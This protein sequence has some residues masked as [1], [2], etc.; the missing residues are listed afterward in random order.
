MAQS[1][2]HPREKTLSAAR[3]DTASDA[4]PEPEKLDELLS[5]AGRG[6]RAVKTKVASGLKE[7]HIK[8][9]EQ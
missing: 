5:G 4:E 8:Q 7:V 3:N 1:G 6:A 9:N 2:L